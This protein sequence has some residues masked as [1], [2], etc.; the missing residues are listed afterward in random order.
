MK[1]TKRIIF[2]L[3]S[4]ITITSLMACGEKK[5]DEQKNEKNNTSINKEDNSINENQNNNSSPENNNQTQENNNEIK[6]YKREGKKIYF[7]TY[8]QNHVTDENKISLL[9]SKAGSIPTSS[10]NGDWTSFNYYN[11]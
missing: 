10:S 2:A 3:T 9:N 11:E 5:Q 1:L 8:P 7:G 6:N 4:V